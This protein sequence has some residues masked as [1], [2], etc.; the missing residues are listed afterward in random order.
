M[1]F[2]SD[3]KAI[4]RKLCIFTFIDE[5]T[6]EC[7]AIELDKSITGQQVS[8]YLNKA[9]FFRG[10][11]K[12]ILTDNGTEFTGNALNARAYIFKSHM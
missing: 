11:P 12:D 1:D 10:R 2:V 6:R 8:R 3:T 5:I 7:I 4:C 9:I